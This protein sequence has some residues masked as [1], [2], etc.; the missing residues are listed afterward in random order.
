MNRFFAFWHGSD[1]IP[2]IS[3]YFFVFFLFSQA[4]IDVHLVRLALAAFLWQ[5]SNIYAL[6][7]AMYL[8]DTG[9]HIPHTTVRVL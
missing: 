7:L 2:N 5:A 4:K 9:T 8:T 6:F 1:Q 3:Q